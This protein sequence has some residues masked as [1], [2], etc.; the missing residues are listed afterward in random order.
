M[1]IETNLRPDESPRNSMKSIV[2]AI[3]GQT[4][5]YAVRRSL[6]I[7]PFYTPHVVLLNAAK[8][9]TIVSNLAMPRQ[10]VLDPGSPWDFLLM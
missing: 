5:G 4:L 10:I 6:G 8:A 7:L 1:Q 3:Y 2:N 9:W